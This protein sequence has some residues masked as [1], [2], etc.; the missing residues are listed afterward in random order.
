MRDFLL[1]L[2][3]AIG[4]GVI[5]AVARTYPTMPT[6]QFGPS[7]FP[8]IIGI[9]MILGGVLLT[10]TSLTAWRAALGDSRGVVGRFDWRGLALSLVPCA[11]VVFYILTA[12][13]LGAMI[14]MAVSMLALMLMRGARLWLAVIVALVV[15]G[16]I[17]WLFSRYLLIPLP[18]GLLLSQRLPFSSLSLAG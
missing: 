9:G 18:E 12:E 1:G 5:V 15:S 8:T 17:Y 4:G 6:L 16:T 14:C 3:F 13:I 10:L 7:L 2:V 11:L